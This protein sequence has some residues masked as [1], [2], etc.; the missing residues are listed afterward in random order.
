MLLSTIK[1]NKNK[2]I[3]KEEAIK[4]IIET[5]KRQSDKILKIVSTYVEDVQPLEISLMLETLA[6]LSS[7]PDS[8]S[9]LQSDKSLFINCACKFI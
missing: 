4:F 7:E 6:S 5:F 8:L 2:E 9:I 3:I 1:E